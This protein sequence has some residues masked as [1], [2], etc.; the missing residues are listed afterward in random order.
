M[1]RDNCFNCH[2]YVINKNRKTFF[3]ED[4]C[5]SRASE[6]DSGIGSSGS[7]SGTAK[8]MPGSIVSS[9]VS[10]CI[11]N[12]SGSQCISNNSM[13][14]LRLM[15]FILEFFVCNKEIFGVRTFKYLIYR[16]YF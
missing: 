3:Q 7:A 11:T 14:N 1:F 12:A 2:P 4:N 6:S 5:L 8:L 13:V 16:S 15:L 9:D 10:R